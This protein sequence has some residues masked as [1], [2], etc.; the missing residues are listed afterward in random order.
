[1]TARHKIVKWGRGD[2][3]PGRRPQDSYLRASETKAWRGSMHGAGALESA[4]FQEL[5]LRVLV[6]IGVFDGL[7]GVDPEKLE[8]AEVVFALVTVPAVADI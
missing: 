2:E 7:S 1:M 4:D 3:N 8:V 6:G 5:Q